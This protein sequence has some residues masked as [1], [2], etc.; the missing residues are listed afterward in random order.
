MFVGRLVVLVEASLGCVMSLVGGSAVLC[1]LACFGRGF[2][3]CLDL[4]VWGTGV[5][6]VVVAVGRSVRGLREALAVSVG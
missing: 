2:R 4:A 1:L 3:C 5:S 6:T